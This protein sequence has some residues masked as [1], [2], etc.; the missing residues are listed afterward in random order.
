MFMNKLLIL[1]DVL[2][3][4]TNKCCCYERFFKFI[5]SKISLKSIRILFHAKV[6]LRW[7][8]IF[9]D[10]ARPERIVFALWSLWDVFSCSNIITLRFLSKHIHSIRQH[11]MM[12]LFRT[13]AAWNGVKTHEYHSPVIQ[14]SSTFGRSSHLRVLGW[15]WKLKLKTTFKYL[16]FDANNL[17]SVNLNSYV[18]AHFHKYSNFPD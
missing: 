10:N 1:F 17:K 4:D 3:L 7:N 13:R 12:T 11:S 14:G 5:M 16:F 2:F 18:A 9:R 8:R 6:K 15:M